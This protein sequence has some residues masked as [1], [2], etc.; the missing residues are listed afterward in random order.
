MF[1]PPV[2]ED[3]ATLLGFFALSYDVCI[4]R[5]ILKHPSPLIAPYIRVILLHRSTYSSCRCDKP[6][7]QSKRL[8]NRFWNKQ[9]SSPNYTLLAARNG[10]IIHRLGVHPLRSTSFSFLPSHT[11]S[12]STLFFA[13]AESSHS[14]IRLSPKLRLLNILSASHILNHYSKPTFHP[15]H[16]HYAHHVI[17][18][19]EGHNLQLTRAPAVI[20]D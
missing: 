4:I 14:T 10:P 9:K 11:L 13:R 3:Q 1:A 19:E 6:S 15:H 18:Q 7:Q 20:F 5:N 12:L 17:E 8:G 16:Y 2:P